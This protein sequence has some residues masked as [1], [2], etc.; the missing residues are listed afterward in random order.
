[1]SAAILIVTHNSGPFIERCL[2]AALAHCREIV[3]VDNV[4]EDSTC[5]QIER[6]PEVRLVRNGT[7]RGFAAAVNQGFREL[8]EE[9]VL[10][11]NPDAVL[12]TGLD[13]LV[14][15]CRQPRV[16]AAGGLLIGEDGRP[17]TGFG[18]RRFPTPTALAFEA[19]GWNRLWPS[20]PVNRRYRCLDRDPLR[21]GEAEQPAGAFLMIRREVWGELGGFEETFHPV[22][23]E[24]VDF[25]RRAAGRGYRIRHVPAAVARHRGAHSVDRMSEQARVVYWYSNLVRYASRHFQPTAFR[26]V[27]L[28]VALGSVARLVT[29]I[30][31]QRRLRPVAVYGKVFRLAWRCLLLGRSTGLRDAQ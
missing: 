13:E 22:W 8:K 17:Q 29:G 20:N 16:A 19:L 24:E 27:C 15:A 21:P 6:F 31:R 12:E 10:L 25:L 3:V 11:L 4:S 18:L 28:A 7:N 23:F 1:M 5:R 14:D 26:W 2:E 9:F 30:V